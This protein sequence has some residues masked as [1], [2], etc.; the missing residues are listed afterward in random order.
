MWNWCFYLI[1]NCSPLEILKLQNN[2]Q[3]KAPCFCQLFI[4]VIWQINNWLD[5]Y[6]FD[7]VSN[8]ASTAERILANTVLHQ[9]MICPLES[10]GNISISTS[11]TPSIA[12]IAKLEFP[13]FRIKGISPVTTACI[14]GIDG[15][16]WAQPVADILSAVLIVILYWVTL[17]NKIHTQELKTVCWLICPKR[18]NWNVRHLGVCTWENLK[19]DKIM[20]VRLWDSGF[21]C[22]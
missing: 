19:K 9:I 4:W 7:F 22:L 5:N 2:L 15:L 17:K 13:K 11:M 21:L 6:L 12:I 16:L 10:G 8:N 1:A 20:E 18:V 14:I 3:L